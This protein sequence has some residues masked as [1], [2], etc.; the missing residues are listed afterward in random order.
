MRKKTNT[1]INLWYIHQNMKV[2]YL[3][4]LV[5]ASVECLFFS[6]LIFGWPSISYVLKKEGYFSN[7]CSSDSSETVEFNNSQNITT[8]S[9]S[10]LLENS[11]A[12]LYS[13]PSISP[14]EDIYPSCKTQV[15]HLN[16][17][18]TISSTLMSFSTLINGY[19][20]DK[21]GTWIS[22]TLAI[23]LFTL[24]SVLMSVSTIGTSWLLYPAMTCFA[25]GGILLLVTNLQI[26]NLF[27]PMRSSVITMCSG[28]L[29]SSSFIF[30]IIKL[31]Y[32]AGMALSTTFII[33][34]CSTVLLWIRTFTLL[35]QRHIPF[36]VTKGFDYG[37]ADCSKKNE[38][39]LEEMTSMTT[40]TDHPSEESVV[41]LESKLSV[42][43]YLRD[44]L[45][46]SNVLHF[47]ILQL[48]NYFFLGT[49]GYWLLTL[50][51]DADISSYLVV[52]GTCQ[53]F[54]VLFA[55]LNGILIDTIAHLL[56]KST[57][58][59]EI[60]PLK[61]AISSGVA[62]SL[63]GTIFSITV[64]IPIINVQYASFILQVIFRSFLYGGNMSFIAIAFP[65]IHFG[66]LY[67]LTMTIGGAIS[68]FQYA[69]FT[70]V[71]KNMESDFFVINIIFVF[72][73]FLTLLHPL[74]VLMYC[75]MKEKS[76]KLISQ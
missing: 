20:Y 19:I 24:G 63:L 8:E 65:S 58:L 49:L 57:T 51:N 74:N 21:Y 67:G 40:E 48:R 23:L 22:R 12:G 2:K 47:S 9:T 64:A 28:A 55:P 11:T 10:T 30:L 70:L 6:G 45:Y 50:S 60:V 26:G 73:S 66:K 13:T 52:F 38:K 46:W 39:I 29:D 41:K 75:R 53:L 32:D 14:A 71:L 37:L 16:L 3:L 27:G 25:I 61:A 7:Y 18:F 33:I 56:K 17:V 1:V 44:R 59:T 42:L 36:P 62:T 5:T 4:S 69:L 31:M 54:G 15:E 68:L 34:T 43:P 76:Q 35:P 72:V